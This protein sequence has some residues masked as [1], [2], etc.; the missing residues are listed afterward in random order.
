M[1]TFLRMAA[2]ACL[3]EINAATSEDWICDKAEDE[4]LFFVPN[5]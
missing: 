2:S 3:D 5:P 1:H 4:T